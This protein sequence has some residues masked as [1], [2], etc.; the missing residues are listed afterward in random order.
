MYVY[1]ACKERCGNN[2][3]KDCLTRTPYVH[4]RDCQACIF[5]L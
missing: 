3:V 5:Y 1:S 2:G 4:P